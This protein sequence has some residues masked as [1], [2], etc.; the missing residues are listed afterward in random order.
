MNRSF[1][2]ITLTAIMALSLLSCSRKENGV[3]LSGGEGLLTLEFGY[4]PSLSPVTRAESQDDMTF[5]V[6]VIDI[7]SGVVVKTVEDHHT[8]QNEPIAL[9]EGTYIIKASNG[10]DVEAGFDSPYF[11]GR[12]TVAIVAGQEASSM[13]TCTMANVKVTV[14]FSDAVKQNFSKYSVDVTNGLPNGTLTY[15]GETLEGQGYFKATGSLVWTITMTNTDGTEYEPITNEI[16]NVKPRDYYNIHFD[17]NGS[18]SAT[19]E[20]GVSVRISVDGTVNE[21]AHDLNVN[22]NKA[23]E[24]AVTEASGAD[25]TDVVRAPQGVGLVGLFNLKAEAGFKRV[26]ITHSSEAVAALG[27]PGTVDILAPEAGVKEAAA[28]AGLTWSD[29][30]EGET[31]AEIDMRQLLSSRLAIGTY[32][33]AVNILDMQSQYVST[34]ITVKVV[35]NVEV[36]TISTNPWAKFA[37]VYAQYNTE[38]EPEGMG[39]EWRKAGESTWTPFSGELTREGTAYSARIGGLEPSTQYEVRA[40][41]AAEHSDDNIMSFTTQAADQLP[42]FNFDSWYKSGKEWYANA[43]LGENYFWDSGNKGANTLSELNPTSPEETFVVSGKAARLESKYVVIAFAGGNIYSGSFGAVSG[44]GASINFGRPYTCRPTALHGWYSYAPKEINRTKAPYDNLKGTMDVAKIYVA[45][46]DWSAPFV[47]NTNT[48]T[49]FD[50]NDPSVIAYGELEDGTGTSGEYREFTINLEY[51]D[52][53]RIP[54][55]VLVVATA[56]KYADYFT[57]GEG[58]LMYIDE[59]EF[60]FE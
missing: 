59:F 25:L 55:H 10:T 49:F 13:I 41:T 52:L 47:V 43:D 5:K 3:L 27:I 51:R 48:G 11:E 6:E 2:Y 9:R 7:R 23:P 30:A 31:G 56:S 8:L 60:L 15:D 16:T 38:S 46:T 37:Y 40:I 29:C 36:S 1:R 32:E 35:P 34:K 18:G 26:T 19:Q 22:L 28:A 44:L 4:D 14:S 17:I 39:F 33:F 20:G 21:Q 50:V 58:S 54:T 24:P 45:L 57:G 12:D 42:N 53:E